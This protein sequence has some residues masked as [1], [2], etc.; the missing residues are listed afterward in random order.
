VL[1]HLRSRR[2]DRTLW[3]RGFTLVELLVVIVILGI[4]AAVVVFAVGGTTDNAQRSACK[5]ELNTVESAVEAF[6][7]SLGVY[8]TSADQQVHPPN[9][10]DGNPVG[11]FLRSAPKWHTVGGQDVTPDAKCAPFEN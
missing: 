10:A 6:N 9:D 4:L 1:K 2:D 3:E 7:S 8:P 11:R 5:A